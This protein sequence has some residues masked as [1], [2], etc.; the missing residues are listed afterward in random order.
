MQSCGVKVAL[1]GGSSVTKIDLTKDQCSA[2]A[3]YLRGLLNN[4]MGAGCFGK[5]EMLVL[6]YRALSA[7]EEIP[8]ESAPP[9]PPPKAPRRPRSDADEASASPASE[10]AQLK[11]VTLERLTA[12]RQK[13]GLTS[14]GPLAA[15]CG[16]VDGK[17]ISA[18]LL[19][20]MLNRERFPVAIW[21]EVAAALDKMERKKGADA[22][23]KDD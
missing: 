14:L 15:L 11:R 8:E 5:I 12:Y 10:A 3:E 9:V 22:D 6:A 19:A 13:E 17:V 20:R 7:A 4:G 23:G 16:K 21:R 2:L 1:R 18:E